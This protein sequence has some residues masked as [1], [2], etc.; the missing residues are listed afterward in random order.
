M[1]HFQFLKIVCA[2]G[3]LT[4]STTYSGTFKHTYGCCVLPFKYSGTTYT[5]CTT[6]G[7]Y[8]PWCAIGISPGDTMTFHSGNWAY[9]ED[10]C[11]NDNFS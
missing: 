6:A 2:G 7:G 9:C 3:C 11:K 1:F 10:Y 4:K 8:D 5:S